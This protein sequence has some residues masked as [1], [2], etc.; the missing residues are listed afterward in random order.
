[1]RTVRP[2]SLSLA[3]VVGLGLI[4]IWSWQ[5]VDYRH[6]Q[7][8]HLAEFDRYGE[9]MLSAAGLALFR[10]CRGGRYDPEE[11]AHSLEEVRRETGS[12]RIVVSG[13]DGRV[14]AEV[15]EVIESSPDHQ[16]FQ[17]EIDAPTPRGRGPRFGRW[18]SE[19][20]V[21]VTLEPGKLDVFVTYPRIELDEKLTE[22]L[23]RFLITGTAL[24]AALGLL[25]LVMGLRLRSARLSLRLAGANERVRA[26]EYL[27]RLGAG[28]VHETRNPLAVV[29]GHAQRLADGTVSEADVARVARTILDETDRTLTRLDEFLLL[30]RPGEPTRSRFGVRELV[31]GLVELL[32]PDLEE[33]RATMTVVGRDFELFAD[34]DHARR[35][36]LNLLLNSLQALDGGGAIRVELEELPDRHEIRVVD[37]GRGI[38]PEIRETIFEPYVTGRPDGTGLGLSIATRIAD[39]HGWC[40]RA[41]SNEPKGTVMVVEV[42]GS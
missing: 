18:N 1:V 17:S 15:G 21:L 7:E 23:R 25:A 41:E 4:G 27:G 19:T 36:L 29:R 39:Q 38:P 8:E 9:A 31:L 13:T 11:L 12:L 6:H 16:L 33:R 3:L 2:A 35:L 30:S 5:W 28:L 20:E 22:D 10:E 14:I 32:G 26:L 40:L 24:S 42:L 34:R 37:D